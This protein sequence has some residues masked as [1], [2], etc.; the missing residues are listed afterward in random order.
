MR[1][2]QMPDGGWRP[3]AGVSNSCWATSL[4]VSLH[5]IN[6]VF[7]QPWERGVRWLLASRG[8]EGGWLERL[9]ALVYKMPVEY[10]RRWKGWPWLP[11]TASWIEPTSHSLLALKKAMVKYDRGSIGRRVD[12]AERMVIDRRS[13]DGGWNYG[14]RRVLDE[15]LPSYPETTAV[16]L[17]GL[18]GS[19][20][21][22]IDPAIELAFRQWEAT[23]S[24]LAKA[25][26]AITLQNYGRALP[27]EQPS[28][29]TSDVML[30]ALEA[31]ATPGGGHQWLK[32]A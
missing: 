3:S 28:E 13:R 17:L 27:V 11:D 20:G 30:T 21:I 23:E 14:N 9:L 4:C 15:D 19:Q 10:D 5:C 8:V 1:S 24:R 32:P 31:I 29:T 18:Q 16:A 26:L 7:D 6:G 12:E 22:Q 25:W 2:W